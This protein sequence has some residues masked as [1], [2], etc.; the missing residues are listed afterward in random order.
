MATV[1]HQLGLDHARL[2]Y[3]NRGV[4]ETLTEPRITKSQVIR[5]IVETPRV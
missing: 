3:P 1:L 2:S 4:D 5:N